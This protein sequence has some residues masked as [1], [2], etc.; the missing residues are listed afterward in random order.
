M[1]G[2]RIL[3]HD[4]AQARE[5]VLLAPL[6]DPFDRMI[7]AAALAVGKPLLTADTR[8]RESGLVEVVWD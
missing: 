5:F 6:R 1:V 7:V 8:I 2:V 4:L 3:P